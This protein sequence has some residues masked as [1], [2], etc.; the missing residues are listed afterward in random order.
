MS[1]I[2]LRWMSVVIVF[3]A[4]T[5]CAASR[6]RVENTLPSADA[7]RPWWRD[8]QPRSAEVDLCVAPSGAVTD[9]R[10]AST[11]GDK[12]Y[13]AALA[14]DVPHWRRAARAT[15]ECERAK[16]TYVP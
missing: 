2:S 3:S 15:S 8:G 6:P 14:Q 13:D 11:S 9:L 16:I 1:K 12:Q 5:A 7:L 10:I 4:M